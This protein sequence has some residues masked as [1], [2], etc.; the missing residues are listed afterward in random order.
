MRKRVLFILGV[1][2]SG[3]VAKSLVSLLNAF[4][5]NAYDV[6]LLLVSKRRGPYAD[7]IPGDVT[8]I[9]D[10]TLDAVGHIGGLGYLIRHGKLALFAGT[11]LRLCVTIFSKAASGYLLSR[12]MPAISGEY[13]LI[14]D[15]NGQQQTYY[16]VD[17][18]KGKR[19]VAFFHSDYAKWP[20]YYSVDKKYYPRVD[21]VLTISPSCVE[22][23]KKFF[24][25]QA[26][27]IGLMP[28]IVS[29]TL[30][31]RLASETINN[32]DFDTSMTSI[33]T[34]GHVS[35]LKGTD[36]ALGAAKIL[37]DRGVAFNWYFIGK[38]IEGC[39]YRRMAAAYGLE[40]Q[41]H[42]MGIIANPYPYINAATIVA[43]T[44]RYEGKSIALDEAK[45]LCK[46]IVV[47]NFTTVQ[48]QFTD[49]HNASIAAMAP[50]A[51]AA[52]IEELL[53]SNELRFK[54]SS[55]LATSISD[56]S[57]DVAKLYKFIE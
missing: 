50:E 22:S 48:D 16:M 55:A 35:Y 1:L 3:G 57:S 38:E 34:V 15:Y 31:S 23:L 25:D 4:D 10:D 44:S 11:L 51:V 29:P 46:P 30:I 8:I 5:R 41:I 45:M 18:L 32:D 7:F 37:K 43:H 28:N 21:A 49:K 14:V 2:D 53:I 13:D 39:K 33:V 40:R 36:I 24:P 12:L 47:T 52:N 19:K 26:H 56:N 54:Y 42:F 27:K 9:T 20:Y 6:S 17:K